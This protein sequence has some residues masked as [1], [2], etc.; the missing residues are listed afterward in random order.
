MCD[1]ITGKNVHL[2]SIAGMY[3]ITYD[4]LN[5]DACENVVLGLIIQCV[6]I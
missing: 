4:D 5:L 2:G 6:M 3:D 1:E